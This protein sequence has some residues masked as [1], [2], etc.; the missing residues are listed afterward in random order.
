KLGKYL[1]FTH[2]RFPQ[3]EGRYDNADAHALRVHEMWLNNDDWL[4]VSPHRYAPIEG[5]NRVDPADIVGDYRFIIQGK[6]TNTDEH[7]SVYVT[8]TNQGRNIQGELGGV[9]KLY[10]GQPNCVRLIID[11]D[12]AYEG[13]AQWQWNVEDQRFE[14]VISAMSASGESLLAA[15]LPQKSAAQVVDDINAAVEQTFANP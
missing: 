11:D 8:L 9:Y 7:T 3:E 13:V 10:D 2:T 4:V 12:T 5:D 15:K 14:V 1:L 6:D